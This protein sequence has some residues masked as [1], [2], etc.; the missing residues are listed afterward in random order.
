MR[1]GGILS[2]VS[3][4]FHLAGST[5]A[6]VTI[7]GGFFPKGPYLLFIGFLL[8]SSGLTVVWAASGVREGAKWARGATYMAAL[9]GG[10]LSAIV[11]PGFI[12]HMNVL[13]VAPVIVVAAH[14]AFVWLV[15]R[16][17]APGT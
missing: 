17:I 2:M 12:V 16:S 11:A 14:A 5:K 9:Q 1:A 15:S 3:G 10:G 13:S 7:H 4:A 6:L 8:I